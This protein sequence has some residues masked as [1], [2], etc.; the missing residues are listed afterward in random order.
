MDSAL[1]VCTQGLIT[2]IQAQTNPTPKTNKKIFCLF[3]ACQVGRPE[4]GGVF[5]KLLNNISFQLILYSKEKVFKTQRLLKTLLAYDFMSF[6]TGYNTF[7]PI[8]IFSTLNSG[9]FF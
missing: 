6:D 8:T 2:S 9:Y 1:R 5:H 3:T 7:D 4:W